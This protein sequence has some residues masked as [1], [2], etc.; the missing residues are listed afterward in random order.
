MSI[1]PDLYLEQCRPRFGAANPERMHVLLWEWMIQTHKVLFRAR[2]ELDLELNFRLPGDPEWCF[3]RMGQTRTRLPDGRTICVAGE[4]EDF[5]DPNFCIYNDVVVL[6]EGCSPEIYGYPKDVFP[7]TDFH[8][9][10]PVGDRLIIIGSLGH[11]RR[12]GFTPVFSL[13]LSTYAISRVETS[14]EMPGWISHH[15][16]EW[17]PKT[18]TITIRGGKIFRCKDGS[19]ELVRSLEEYQLSLDTGRWEQVSDHGNWRQFL[20]AR[21]DGKRLYPRAIEIAPILRD[22][23]ARHVADRIDN[24]H[25]W[26][27]AEVYRLNDTLVAI[28]PDCNEWHVTIESPLAD[29]LVSRLIE[30]IR[31]AL[32]AS[33]GT[34]VACREIP[35]PSVR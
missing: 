27:N 10:T 3:V 33:A 29:E 34:P 18:R 2:E 16:A 6:R 24:E 13:D 4:H 22:L 20:L 32:T 17:D 25:G 26:L 1:T 15:S 9:A 28:E 23:P 19:E 14:G 31:N 12:P 5:Y 35:N 21:P 11:Q 7:P 8:T 30:T